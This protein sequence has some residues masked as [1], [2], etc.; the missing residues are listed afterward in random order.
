MHKACTKQTH[1]PIYRV[2]EDICEKKTLAILRK[3][4]ATGDSNR[5][6][7]TLGPTLLR[8]GIIMTGAQ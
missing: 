8:S 7:V 4:P 6:K 1:K 2:A 5:Q 3:E